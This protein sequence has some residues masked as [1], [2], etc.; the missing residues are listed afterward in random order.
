MRA[1]V[2]I[3]PVPLSCVTFSLGLVIILYAVGGTI[4]IVH[5]KRDGGDE[6]DRDAVRR[7]V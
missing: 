3:Y 1:I 4:F 2:S 6:D 7:A 5:G